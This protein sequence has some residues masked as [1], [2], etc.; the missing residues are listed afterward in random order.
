MTVV[1][2]ESLIPETNTF[3]RGSMNQSFIRPRT[4]GGRSFATTTS[5]D[6][7]EQILNVFADLGQQLH[8]D[9]A[10]PECC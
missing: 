9:Y 2:T 1:A 4:A 7:S 10:L 6:H 3:G 8:F 5:I